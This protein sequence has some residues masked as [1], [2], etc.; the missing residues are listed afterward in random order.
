MANQDTGTLFA[1]HDACI[2]SGALPSNQNFGASTTCT[3]S[4]G[5]KFLVKFDLSSIPAGA[6]I[7]NATMGMVLMEEG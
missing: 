3:F 6:E 4:S 2:Q 1:T 5:N 7:I